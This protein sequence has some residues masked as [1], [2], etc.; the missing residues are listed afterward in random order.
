MNTLVTGGGGFLGRYIVEQL[1]QRGDNV[2]VFA[3]G[4]YPELK[5][6]GATLIRGDLQDA[7]AVSSACAG[8]DAVF[9]VAAKASYWGTWESFMRPNVLGTQN[10]INACRQQGV[11]K[12]I[13]TSTPSV[14][15]THHNRSGANESLPY[16][17]CFESYYCHSKAIAEQ[18]VV[19]AS[20]S[21]LL[22]VSLRPHIVFGP[23]D[24]QII[25]RLVARARQGKLIRV[26]DG[27]NKVDATYVEDAARAHLQAADA[28]EPG[29]TVAGSTYF[30]SQGEPVYL[31]DFVNEILTR[32][33]IAP[34]KRRISLPAAR[35]I[36]S[37][38]EFAYR[39][40]S[41]K[42]EPRLTRFLADEL[43][44]EHYYD[45]SAAKRDLGY[46]PQLTMAEAVERT[47]AYFKSQ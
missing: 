2:S 9:H 47:V 18:S 29:S 4:S 28:L 7:A 25:P 44:L 42:G 21:E 12:L 26:G 11:R 13:Y 46:Q 27:R 19:K 30:I 35:R 5:Q 39:R 8:T 20:D 10:I 45:I 36:G 40:F 24:T 41:L 22:T 38:M 15:A 1:L 37:A 31:W 33:D 14:V 34:V 6:I 3:R 17:T 43:A 32:L 16:P 23:R